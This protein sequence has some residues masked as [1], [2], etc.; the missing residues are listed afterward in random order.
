MGLLSP[1]SLT[2]DRHHFDV[3]KFQSTYKLYLKNKETDYGQ[4]LLSDLI[5]T[6]I[7][8]IRWA[9]SRFD[10]IEFDLE[11]EMVQ[12]AALAC[13]KALEQ[14]RLDPNKNP[15]RWLQRLCLWRMRNVVNRHGPQKFNFQAYGILFESLVATLP[16]QKDVE[17]RLFSDQLKRLASKQIES[18]LRFKGKKREACIFILNQILAGEV[19][20][21]KTIGDKFQISKP[22][23]FVSYVR[24]RLRLYLYEFRPFAGDKRPEKQW[25]KKIFT[26]E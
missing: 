12:V 1:Y 5:S 8:T 21:P 17:S 9:L 15:E 19:V 26:T 14:A 3:A 11:D 18:N 10:H 24:L 20:L 25:I 16:S 6:C 7:P 23:F 2:K 13:W 22:K 4:V